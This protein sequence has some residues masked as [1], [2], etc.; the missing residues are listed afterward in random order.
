MESKYRNRIGG[1]KMKKDFVVNVNNK[2]KGVSEQGFGLILVFDHENEVPYMEISNAAD[3]LD[4]GI[5]V[6]DKGYKIVQKIFMQKPSPVE[7]AYFGKVTAEASE[8]ETALL[9]LL[10]EQKSDWFVF[11]TTDNSNETLKNNT[12]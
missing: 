4:K 8:V 3:L 5:T 7:V 6:D 2:T 11:T 1:N 9:G 10:N 12:K